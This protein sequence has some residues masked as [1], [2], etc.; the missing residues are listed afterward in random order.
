MKNIHEEFSSIDLLNFLYSKLGFIFH[1]Q[2]YIIT[3]LEEALRRS[4]MV[5]ILGREGM[6]KSSAIAKFI[7][8]HKNVYYLRI[9]TTYRISDF[10]NEMLFQ[11]TGVYP[12]N[13]EPLFTK[14]KMLS[15]ELTK[16]NSKKLIIID[17]AGRLSPRALSVF[18]ELRDN[19]IQCTGF[20]FIGLDYFHTNL[21]RAR[22]LNVPGIAEFL[23]RVSNFYEVPS[24]L[25]NEI[26][27]YGIEHKLD[28][29]QTLELRESGCKTIAELENTV[30][31]ILEDAD[32]AAKEGRAPRKV[33]AAGKKVATTKAEAKK[34]S[35]AEANEKDFEDDEAEREDDEEDEAVEKQKK[36]AAKKAREA[37]KARAKIIAKAKKETAT[38]H[39]ATA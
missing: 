18:F 26:S 11:V 2:N 35:R 14:M 12:K 7:N 8:T 39:A 36:E 17:D 16:D 34:L 3:I 15:H 31:A 20:V 23:R 29:D 24:L 25:E 32:D 5:G 22:K 6:G 10:F 27:A 19:T 33:N 9:G 4:R 37:K 21:L 1:A 38:K 30:Q 28:E 13:H